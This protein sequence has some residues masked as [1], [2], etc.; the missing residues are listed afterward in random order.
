MKRWVIPDLHGCIKTL[1]ALLENQI[2]PDENDEIYFLG[3]YIDRGPNPKGVLDYI[4]NMQDQGVKIFPLIGNHEEYIL[5]ALENE[6]QRK[7]KFFFFKERNKLLDEWVRSGGYTTLHS[8]GVNSV[9]EIPEKYIEWIK[10]LKFFYEL[11]DYVLVHAG[12]NF[13]RKD[14]FEDHHAIL[15]TKSFTPEPEKI[16]NK[17]VIHGHVPVSLD[18]LKAVLADP[19]KKYIPLDTGCYHPDKPGMG[20]LVA[21][22]LG[23]LDLKIQ[24]NVENS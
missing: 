23:S 18:F 15:W 7:R 10:N 22:E 8:F 11:D 24:K 1:K 2:K 17:T 14:P 6:T 20:V 12:L 21:L 3:D 19:S 13:Y 9:T 16:H 4:M 5:L